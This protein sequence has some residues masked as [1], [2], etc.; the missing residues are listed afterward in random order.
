MKTGPFTGSAEATHE[1][2]PPAGQATYMSPRESRSA[3]AEGWYFGS[4]RGR[5]RRSYCSLPRPIQ[6]NPRQ[7]VTMPLRLARAIEMP[8]GTGS[9][10]DHGAFERET[11]RVFV[12]HTGRDRVE[13]I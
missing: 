8:D 5:A 4:D 2:P 3:L 7:E 9:S 12:A 11:G 6:L 13:V 1:P 10:F